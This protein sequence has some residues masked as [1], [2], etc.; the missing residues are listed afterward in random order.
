MTNVV[1]PLDVG[2]T[3]SMVISFT[4]PLPGKYRQPFSM[5]ALAG[6]VGILIL[7]AFAIY[8]AV[9][10]LV[11]GDVAA[12]WFGSITAPLLMLSSFQ[13]YVNRVQDLRSKYI[14]NVFIPFVRRE[15]VIPVENWLQDN[16][17]IGYE[18]E[19]P[20]I[21][22]DFAGVTLYNSFYSKDVRDAGAWMRSYRIDADGEPVDSGKAYTVSILPEGKEAVKV[23][24]KVLDNSDDM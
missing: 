13:C 24:F 1:Q 18:G 9:R 14:M 2:A 4:E 12:V 10:G 23:S 20:R 21:A 5:S 6:P 22:W 7:A 11:I 3:G 17:M 15:V 19:P 16:G 8:V